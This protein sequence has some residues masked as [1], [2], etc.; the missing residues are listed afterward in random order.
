MSFPMRAQAQTTN[1]AQPIVQAILFYSPTCPHCHTVIAEVLPPIQEEYGDQLQILGVDVSHEVGQQLYQE[2]ITRLKIAQNRLGVPTLV[3]GDVV[4]V[5]SVEIPQQFP[6]L[7]AAGIAAGGV[8]WPDI[9]TLGEVVADLPPSADPEIVA[10]AAAANATMET[11]V[12]QTELATAGVAT[13]V[14]NLDAATIATEVEAVI[15]DPTGFALAWAIMVGMVISLA[16]VL[17]R[18]SQARPYLLHLLDNRQEPLLTSWAV[19]LLT[20]LGLMVAAYLTYVEVQHVPAVCGP[21]GQCNVVQASP[22][23]RI[24]GVPVAV[25]GLINYLAVGGLWLWQ[26][27][28]KQQNIA[29]YGLLGITI[30]GTF[31]SIYLTALELFAIHAVCAWCLT[32][33]VVTTL[34]MVVVVAA[35][36]KRPSFI[37][38]PALG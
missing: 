32:S 3:V 11:A 24:L 20:L 31:F 38:Q 14:R 17:L 21:V 27:V 2:A 37:N 30:F 23:A 25:L 26:L 34:L 4:L 22:Y 36:T 28:D 13:D 7:I 33:A 8:G 10:A 12:A 29:I 9:P 15:P 1:N 5:G 6:Q 19:P 35:L 18:F 16:F